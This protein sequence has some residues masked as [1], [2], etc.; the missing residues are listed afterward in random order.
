VIG[1]VTSVVFSA[2]SVVFSAAT[3]EG[4]VGVC[5][6]HC[7]H[8]FQHSVGAVVPRVRFIIHVHSWDLGNIYSWDADVV[9]N[10]VK[11]I[12]NRVSHVIVITD[13]ASVAV[14]ESRLFGLVRTQ[15]VY[16]FDDYIGHGNH[17]PTAPSNLLSCVQRHEFESTLC[18]STWFKGNGTLSARVHTVQWGD[19]LMHLT[20]LSDP[21]TQ[22]CS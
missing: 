5:R 4:Q 18:I 20:L 12:I 3:L 19:F 17:V 2:A 15:C 8:H 21:E 14:S 11:I 16:P 22:W 10:K 9:F 13:D 1:C 7:F 6:D